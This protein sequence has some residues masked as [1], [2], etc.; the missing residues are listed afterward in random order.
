M[1]QLAAGILI[2]YSTTYLIRYAVNCFSDAIFRKTTG[3][4]KNGAKRTW[5]RVS[6]YEEPK[7]PIEYEL[8]DIDRE[9]E[10]IFDIQ[11]G[12]R[13]EN[14]IFVT[15]KKDISED[16]SILGSDGLVGSELL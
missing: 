5:R 3:L 13:S 4:L 12:Y 11:S 8:I 9:P 15:S 6:G 16:F 2:S 7:D 1:N 14:R 10:I